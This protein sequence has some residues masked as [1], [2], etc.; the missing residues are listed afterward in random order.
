MRRLAFPAILHSL[1]QTFV[2]V[3]DRVMLGHHADVSL[4][5]MQI[6]GPL[7][8]SVWSIFAAFEVGTIAR[9]GRHV[10]AG[11]P[12]E[13]R[14]AAWVSFCLA[15]VMG[16]LVALA[17]PFVVLHLHDFAPRSSPEAIAAARDYLQITLAASPMVFIGVTAIAVLQA[18]G[19]T[20]T[21]LVIGAFV[22]AIHIPLNRVMILGAFGLPALGPRGCAMSTAF[23]FTLQAG[24]AILALSRRG[25]AVSLHRTES[26]KSAGLGRRSGLGA[27]AKE[28][29]R[30]GAP[31]FVERV[32]YHAGYVGFVLII[33]L[34][35]DRAM[36]ANQALI[37]AESI[38]FLSA[39]GFGIA[40]A[41]LVAQKL[42][43]ERPDEAEASA[44]IAA[45]YAIG[46]L[47][48]AGLAFLAFRSLILSAFTTDP[49]IVAVGA[50]AV[51]IL[52]L[53][54]PFM[55][56]GTVLGQSLRGAGF[57][58][59]VLVVSAI[60]ALGVRIATTWLFAIVLG[61]GLT[62]VWLGSTCDWVART[63]LLVIVGRVRARS[64]RSAMEPGGLARTT[65]A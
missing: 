36:A 52:A 2:F 49:A 54:Q 56:I 19:D 10:G 17:S 43:A 22:N 1:L 12:D 25:R 64:L 14:R 53:A 41:A 32:L 33:A 34:L 39:D 62:G 40:A 42:G 65:P 4:A 15:A 50:A 35:G 47:S 18:G 57:T 31:A 6:A 55:A 29:M 27:E 38:C 24:L 23:T 58:R 48:T 20:R 59:D 37:S 46:L 16:S 9:V 21:P 13:A 45:F 7:E 26:M 11:R 3:V 51:P 61:M 5:A 30:I 60:S 8:W 28:V 63:I 44:R